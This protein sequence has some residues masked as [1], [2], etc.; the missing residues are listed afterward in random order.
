LYR[1]VAARHDTLASEQ[2]E[3]AVGGA[4]LFG[5]RQVGFLLIGGG[6]YKL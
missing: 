3:T 5:T 6:L 4:S 2:L 1:Y